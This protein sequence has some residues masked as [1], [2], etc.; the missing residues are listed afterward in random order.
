MEDHRDELVVI[1]AGYTGPMTGFINSNPGL[2]SRFNKYIYFE[3]YD[4]EQLFK[5]FSN[6]CN[7]NSYT[8]T[9]ESKAAAEKLFN[10]LY[11]E[12]NENFGNARDVRNRFEDMVS[13]QANRVAELESPTTDDLITVLPEDILDEDELEE[14]AEEE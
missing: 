14:N 10:T 3:D 7:K 11:E 2:E 6:Y 1:V 12:R 5:I 4:G 9:D 13:R 8:M